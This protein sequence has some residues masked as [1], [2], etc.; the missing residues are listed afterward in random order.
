MDRKEILKKY[1]PDRENLLYILHDIQDNKKEKYL[2]EED[3]AEVADFCNISKAEI[4]GVV[5]FYTMFS[6]RKRGKNVI[7]LCISPPCHMMGA[8]SA[9]DYL[10]KKLSIKEGE[11]T[12]D[13]LFTIETAACLGICAVAPAMMINDEMYGNLTPNKIDEIINSYKEKTN[14]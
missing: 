4:H 11:T 12:E 3:L 8:Q 1:T 7:R 14:D 5:T 6:V 9:L 2:S 10:K 13:G